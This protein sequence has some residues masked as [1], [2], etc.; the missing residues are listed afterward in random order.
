MLVRSKALVDK[1]PRLLELLNEVITGTVFDDTRR[2]KE[3]IQEARSRMEMV[4][5][6]SGN[7]MAMNRLSS[8]FSPAGKYT[9]LNS[10]ISF[11]HFL[12]N[13]ERDFEAR[14]QELAENL[15]KAA[16]MIFRKNSLTAGITLPEEDYGEFARL[17]ES[18]TGSLP[19]RNHGRSL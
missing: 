13:A 9:E 8:Y 1:L 10:G 18:F 16:R 17:F 4:I 3:I 12:S 11:Y 5:N 14:S 2:L 7:M 19:W 6:Q 15:K